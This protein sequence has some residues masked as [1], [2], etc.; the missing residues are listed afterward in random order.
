MRLSEYNDYYF[1][2]SKERMSIKENI[3]VVEISILKTYIEV[4]QIKK[5][6]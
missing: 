5:K 1:K 4:L 3:A 2:T 6:L